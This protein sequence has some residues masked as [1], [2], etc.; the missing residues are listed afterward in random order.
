MRYDGSTALDV[1]E[2]FM[3]IVRAEGSTGDRCGI[4]N[5]TLD[6]AQFH[7]TL[8]LLSYII[9]AFNAHQVV[10]PHRPI[11]RD[12]PRALSRKPGKVSGSIY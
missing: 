10:A 4:S 1:I 11:G 2:P 3:L 8:Q 5:C 12:W 6:P 7:W 9:R